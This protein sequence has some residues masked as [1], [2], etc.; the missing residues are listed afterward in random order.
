MDSF[1][2]Y[3][4]GFRSNVMWKKIVACTYYLFCMLMLT[5]GLPLFLFLLSIPFVFFNLVDVINLKKANEPLRT[6]LG[7][8]LIATCL[9]FGSVANVGADAE[10]SPTS[11][12]QTSTA[13]SQVGNKIDT[14][15]ENSAPEKEPSTVTG[16]L[17]VHFID[18][19]QA[20]CI[21]IQ[22]N[23]GKSMLI[24]A[25]NNDDAD[26]IVNYI[27]K[28][29]IT[30]FDYVVGT[31]PHE[32]HAGSLDTVINAFEVENII[33]PKVSHNTQTY[34]DVL[35]AIKNKGLKITTPVP[36][37][38]YKL[39]DAAFTLVAPNSDNYEELNNYSVS[40]KLTHGENSFLFTGDA[41]AVSE[42]EMLKHDLKS[43]VL[44]VGH[45][46]SDSSTTPQFLN[47]ASPKYAIISVGKDN[48][49]GHPSTTILD[50]LTAANI[51]IYR[52]D[53]DGTII[54]TSDGEKITFEKIAS[55]VKPNAP[56]EQK[57][58]SSVG[59]AAPAPAPV[60][61]AQPQSDN[62]G[63][64]ITVYVTNTGAKY[65]CNGCSSLR[66]SKIPISLQDAKA[67]GYEPCGRCHPP[68]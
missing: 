35:T 57:T 67:Q 22:G 3:I 44:K 6:P 43:D 21:L 24:D 46:G 26:T 8:C 52:T 12:V 10:T 18:V 1:L 16:K 50:R 39:G 33:M 30:K 11:S 62:N 9:M 66:K 49:Y 56:P 20:D 23:D 63:N 28:Q 58:T 55:S 36:G 37:T 15:N 51:E 5:G 17:S 25:G 42:N 34:L 54:A 7:I 65:H 19:G 2:D 59:G 31:H 40:I 13:P 61:T 53:Q 29:N 45:H 48:K 27:Q 4:P 32:D 41:E 68:Q 38:E 60:T 47:K 14:E 64:D